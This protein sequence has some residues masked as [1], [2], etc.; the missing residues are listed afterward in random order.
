MPGG[1]LPDFAKWGEV[2]VRP[3][4]NIRRKTA[5]HLSAAWQAPHVTQHDKADVTALEEF[6]KTYGARVEKAGGKLTVTAILIKIVAMAI[7]KF[8]QF[9]S[10]VDMANEHD[11]VQEV[12]A[13]RRR[14]GH[15][16]RAARAGDPRRGSTRPSRR[17][18][19]D[20]A[21]LSQ[22]ARDKQADPRRDGGRRVL[23]HESRRHR[24]H[25]IYADH[26]PA[27][28]RDSRRLADGAWSRSGRTTRSC[29]G[30]CCRCR[31]RTTTAPLTAPTPR[32]SCASSPMA[33]SSR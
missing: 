5:E 18:P 8:P 7:A 27:G 24:R 11:R 2:D 22:K 20:L 13:H 31:C 25:V 21:A 16:Q 15:A 12:H 32:A 23:D 14:G 10:S 29:H 6:R 30:R 19:L 33:W 9:A 4:S 26:Q 17:S 3:M 28:S 1:E